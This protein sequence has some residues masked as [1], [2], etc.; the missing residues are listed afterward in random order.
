[1]ILD[2]QNRYSNEQAVTT[3]AG[4]TNVI[5]HGPLASGNT[6][7][8][9]GAGDPLF[10]Y[11]LVTQ[12]ATAAGAATVTFTLETDTDESFG[13][14]VTLW[15]SGA[16]G[17]ATLVAGYTFKIPLPRGA[18]ERYTRLKYTVATGPLTAGKFTAALV[19][20]VED[21]TKAAVGS[22]ITH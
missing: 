21:R 4:S 18:Y 2:H 20:N 1:M 17:K 12:T 13:S 9:L 22:A 6:G 19:R 11:L 3:T 5:D 14:A 7:R 10:L 16:I 8:D 15:D